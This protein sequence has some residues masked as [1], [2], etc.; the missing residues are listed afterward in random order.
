MKTVEQTK[1]MLVDLES[2]L[3]QELENLEQGF[4]EK[5]FEKVNR[6][7][8]ELDLFARRGY[9]LGVEN[10]Y[11][12][13]VRSVR[14]EFI[15]MM[16]DDLENAGIDVTVPVENGGDA[17]YFNVLGERLAVL[18]GEFDSVRMNEPFSFEQLEEG[19]DGKINRI[20]E[21]QESL[22]RNIEKNEQLI[23]VFQP[24]LENPELIRTEAYHEWRQASKAYVILGKTDMALMLERK[25][26]KWMGKLYSKYS[27]KYLLDVLKREDA[28][29]RL[30]EIV[31]AEKMELEH[32]TQELEQNEEMISKLTESK[33]ELMRRAKAFEQILKDYHL[34]VHS[35]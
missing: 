26:N 10:G 11:A 28:Q 33:E 19:I 30:E 7:A 18:Y 27:G 34:P 20:R 22:N 32:F 15:V 25:K 35:K 13:F 5:N 4:Q 2:K 12:R 8:K 17:I 29:K 6:A 3:K 23:D 21:R 24:L 16:Q 31:R 1:T 9:D 14:R